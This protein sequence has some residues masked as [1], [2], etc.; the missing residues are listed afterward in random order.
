MMNIRIRLK[1]AKE[2]KLGLFAQN[3]VQILEAIKEM[4]E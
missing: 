1:W 2:N 4:Y 3:R